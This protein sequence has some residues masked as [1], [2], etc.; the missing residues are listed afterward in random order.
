MEKRK[1]QF[2]P[3]TKIR[4]RKILCVSS[5]LTG[6]E[7]IVCEFQK[8][9]A[10]DYTVKT[11]AVLQGVV[12]KRKTANEKNDWTALNSKGD[13]IQEARDDSRGDDAEEDGVRG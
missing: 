10:I 5:T 6:S 13:D 7:N 9:Y 1:L 11:A 2:A 12:D 3:W 4:G 8:Q